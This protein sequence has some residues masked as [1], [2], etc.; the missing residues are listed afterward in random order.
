M[1]SKQLKQIADGLAALGK[2]RP[3]LGRTTAADTRNAK[4]RLALMQR[5]EALV[6]S[7]SPADRHALALALK[8]MLAPYNMPGTQAALEG[9]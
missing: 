1:D 5:F 4:A 6:R 3:P 7:T 2:P 9:K 8:E